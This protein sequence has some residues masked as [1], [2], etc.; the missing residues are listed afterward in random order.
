MG[1]IVDLLTSRQFLVMAFAAIA[2]AA[3]VWTLAV[4]LFAGNTLQKRMKAVALERE[5]IRARER[6][7]MTRADRATLRREPKAFMRQVV[8]MFDLTR[9]F[10]TENARAQLAMAGLRG[11]G[12]MVGFLF[13]RAASTIIVF[14]A[15]GIYLFFISHLAWPW[16]MK[17][18]AAIAAAYIG[19]KL[20]EIYVK[21][22]ITKRQT[23]IKRSFPD[24]LDLLLICVESGM[25]VE[26][27]FRRV[28]QEIGVQSVALAEELILTTAEMSYLQDRRAAFENLSTRTGLEGVKAVVSA[29]IQA[30]RYGTPVA[31]ALRV[32][33]QENRDIRMNDAEKK[34]AG[35]PPKLTVPMI[36]FFLPV[37]FVI[38]MA[39][40]I[41]QIMHI[42]K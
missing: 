15:A 20:P 3:T 30:E 11:P 32:L 25:S 7:R 39:P 13:A 21:N 24:A 31:Q 16:L 26:A 4:P 2:A 12:P 1:H 36:L 35:L 19:L 33:A 23:S 29:L 41:M 6:E 42:M 27:A 8:E 10:G 9:H 34:A 18:A 17:I 40:A 38:I 5:R 22:L 37:L 14:L 28:S